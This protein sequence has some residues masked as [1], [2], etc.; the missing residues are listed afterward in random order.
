MFDHVMAVHT[1]VLQLPVVVV[2]LAVSRDPVSVCFG[3]LKCETKVQFHNSGERRN[4]FGETEVGVLMKTRVN[5]YVRSVLYVS[6]GCSVVDSHPLRPM[7]TPSAHIHGMSMGGRSLFKGLHPT[8]LCRG[9]KEHEM[10]RRREEGEKKRL[11][12]RPS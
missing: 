10:T 7:A 11:S 12:N 1:V 5:I 2:V 4:G 9:E 8:E 3:C 6:V